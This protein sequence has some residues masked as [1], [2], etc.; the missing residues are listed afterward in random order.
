[1]SSVGMGENHTASYAVTIF[2]PRREVYDFWRRWENLPQ[3]ARHLRSVEDLG[4][5]RTRW[6]AEGPREDVTWEAETIEDVTDERIVWRS[7]GA[8]DV[9]NH[10][11]VTFQDAPMDRGTEV[12]ARLA[13]DIPYG[14]FGELAAKATGTSPEAEIA[15][16]MRRFKCILECGELPVIEGQSSNRKRGDNMPGDPS[17]KA[18]VR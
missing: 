16:A 6:T 18:G 11:V 14:F 3:F 12:V 9:P 8:S 7:V 15:E 2:R 10:G 17:P 5:N 4:N 13:Y 1:M